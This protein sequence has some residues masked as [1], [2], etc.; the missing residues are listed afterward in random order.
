VAIVGETVAGFV[1]VVDDEVEQVYVA[2]E[3]RGTHVAV[4]LLAEAECLV[5][6]N[7][8]RRAWLAVVAGNSRA[9]RFYE[10]HGWIDDGLVDYPAATASGRILVQAH[11]Y[12]KR[13]ADEPTEI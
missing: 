9:R 7:G 11:R 8:H 1:M 12:A 13:V 4:V 5:A 3:Y 6:M 2:R 10:R